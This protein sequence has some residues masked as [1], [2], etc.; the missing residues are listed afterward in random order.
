[1]FPAE[2]NSSVGGPVDHRSGKERGHRDGAGRSVEAAQRRPGRVA[3]EVM[4]D[5][6]PELLRAPSPDVWTTTEIGRYLGWLAE[7]RSLEFDDY[8][9]L[10]RWSVTDLEGF[11][12]SI[13]DF[14]DILEH[15]P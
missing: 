7:N 8:D 9:A 14:F 11:W 1:M 3:H 6:M 12:S 5:G 10:H 2:P 15:T 13:R 4:G